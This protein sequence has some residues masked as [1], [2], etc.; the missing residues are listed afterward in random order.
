VRVLA[1][2]QGAG[3]CSLSVVVDPRDAE[4]TLAQIHEIIVGK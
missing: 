1:V 4:H 2:A 3:R